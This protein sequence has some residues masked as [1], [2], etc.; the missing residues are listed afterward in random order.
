MANNNIP[1]KRSLLGALEMIIRNMIEFTSNKHYID[2]E[3]NGGAIFMIIFATRCIYV[4][5]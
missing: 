4:V 1:K 2:S 5:I 3:I